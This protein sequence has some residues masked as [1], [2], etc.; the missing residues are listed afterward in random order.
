MP[1]KDE[2]K[3]RSGE[4]EMW[5]SVNPILNIGEP[6][7][8]LTLRK[9]KVGD[10]VTPWNDLPFDTGDGG[11]D[12]GGPISAADVSETSTRKWT[13][14]TEKSTWNSKEDALPLGTSDQY[15]QGNKVLGN[16]AN[17]VLGVALAGISFASAL[18]VSAV[19]TVLGAFGKVQAQL[20]SL[21][22]IKAD[23]AS[24]A[25]TGNPTVPNQAAG[26]NSTRAANTAY[27]DTAI[28][29]LIN[30]APG[31]LDTLG[32]LAAQMAADESAVASLT[33]TVAGKL[34][35]ASNL[36]D[37]TNPAS[38]R[39]NLGLGN[40]ENTAISTWAGS[41]NLTTLGT[42]GSGTWQGSLIAGQYGGTGVNNSGKTITLGGNFVTSGAFATT[43]TV[44]GTTNVTL[45]T[46]GTLATISD[47]NAVIPS[48]TGNSGKYL[49]TNGTTLSWATV[50]G[51]G[52]AS[53]PLT[54][55]A[56]TSSEI[57]LT[58]K[59]AASQTASLLE[60]KDSSNNVLLNIDANGVITSPTS[61]SGTRTLF[62]FKG[63]TVS[64]VTLSHASTTGTL[65]LGYGAAV[66]D[67]INGLGS[68][69]FN[70][71]NYASANVISKGG[72]QVAAFASGQGYYFPTTD[73]PL[74]DI[75]PTN[76]TCYENGTTVS[77]A[78]I[79]IVAI[80]GNTAG[81][82][83]TNAASL[84]IDGAPTQGANETITNKYAI[85]V[86]GGVSKFDGVIRPASMANA[87]APNDSIYYSTDASKLVYKDSGGT[88]NNLY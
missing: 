8:D 1:R 25:F 39:T 24:P 68:F 64:L 79:G 43:L 41:A 20:S 80:D 31:A 85:W 37:L 4:S 42:I 57:P 19:D 53:S 61:A 47:V 77:I 65:K 28:A 11:G 55:T 21:K 76:L 40:V 18:D 86:K 60:F 72:I 16:F 14:P 54:L 22:T 7:R 70:H 88:V 15:F 10:G 69:T 62:D 17:V 63:G 35:K 74:L 44:T 50:S 23:L 67:T 45:P 26:N 12:G 2:I 87:S 52:G 6:G 30:S 75:N 46:T 78:R 48:Q 56:S 58:L 82:T 29:N 83:L 9:T 73:A 32:E 71:G 3:F 49:T 66:F 81:R 84:T 13:S 33:T 34:A 5:E 36:S 27:V 38:A 59:G 51:G